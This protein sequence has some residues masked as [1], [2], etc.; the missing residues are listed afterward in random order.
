MGISDFEAV[1]DEIQR[2]IQPGAVIRNWGMARGFTG[3][4]FIIDDVGRSSVTVS[5]G[6]MQGSRRVSKGDFEKLYAVW[7][8]YL[9]GNYPRSS[10]LLLSHNSTYIVSILKQTAPGRR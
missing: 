2:A 4:G 5:G 10:M 1:W 6:N 3:G 9:A 8:Q 7:D